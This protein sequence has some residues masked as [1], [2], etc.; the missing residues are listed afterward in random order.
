M[1]NVQDDAI[2]GSQLIYFGKSSRE[3]GKGEREEK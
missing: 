3:G 1:R 2:N